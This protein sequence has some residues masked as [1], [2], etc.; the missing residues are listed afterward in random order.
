MTMILQEEN[1]KDSTHTRTHA[2]TLTTNKSSKSGV[3]K[4]NTQ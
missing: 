1:S 2:Q 4:I 3:F